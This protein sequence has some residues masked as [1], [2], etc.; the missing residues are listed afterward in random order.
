MK[1]KRILA[2]MLAAVFFP[3]AV[4]ADQSNT[5]SPT[6][7]TVSGLQLTTNYN[8]AFKAMQTCNSGATAPTNDISGAAVKGQCW[9]D[10]SA[11]PNI[12]KRHD[13]TSWTILGY[14]DTTNHIWIPVV[15]GYNDT[16]ASAT[17]TDLCSKTASSLSVTGVT[18]ITGFASACQIGQTKF[19][20]FAGALTLTHSASLFLPNGASNV[21][22]A[23]NDNALAVYLG[24]GN[25][26]IAS[27]TKAD[28]SS[29]S[30]NAN[31][32]A[33]VSFT[34][35]I[36]PAA[37]ASGVTDDYNPASLAT[38]ETLRLTPNAAGST[39]AGLV[40]GTDGRQITIFNIGTNANLTI[41]AGTTSTAAN[42]FQLAFPLILYPDESAQ[43][44][45]DATSS[46][47]RLASPQRPSLI[48]GS[49]KNLKVF[50]DSG[51]PTTTMDVTADELTVEDSFGNAFR[52]SSVSV[53]PVI[54]AS[55]A[56]GLDTGTI[57]ANTFYS[58][59]VIYN[60]TT[61]TV[62]GL[63]SIQ[64]NCQNATPVSGYTACAHVGWAKVD[65]NGAS[66]R[67]YRINC[68]SK[69]CQY[70]VV[71]ATNTPNMPIVAT[72]TAGT[73]QSTYASVTIRG[74]SGAIVWCPPTASHVTMSTNNANG[75]ASQVQMAPSTA[76]GALAS[77]NSPVLYLNSA[78]GQTILVR[79]MFESDAIAWISSASGGQISVLG[80]TDNATN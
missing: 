24:S 65:N 45:Y 30:A 19:L 43:F 57:S 76:Y 27:Y 48:A 49:S 13:G 5:W 61:N 17:T 14:I 64:A 77:A 4:L 39:L 34:G 18:T 10:T 37:L 73:V 7:G 22:T 41:G 40:G 3:L 46:R 51:A 20:R 25:W 72:G 44:R 71:A 28:G 67:F 36:A 69:D 15:G 47:W 42:R 74:T 56:N 16:I 9:L 33:A 75:V 70:Q 54:T 29:L 1:F 21:T 78:V 23:A 58:I 66:S 62:A 52:L 12:Y 35:D 68:A 79:F 8:N 60:P 59:N 63:I 80:W 38:S 2:T 11:T 6:T 50:N 55:G 26:V 31:L 32:T 53:A